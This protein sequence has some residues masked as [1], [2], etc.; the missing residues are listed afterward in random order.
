MKNDAN[1]IKE[2]KSYKLIHDHET[3]RGHNM[4]FPIIPKGTTCLKMAT[5]L[6]FIPWITKIIFATIN[7]VETRTPPLLHSTNKSVGNDHN[8]Y[9]RC[10]YQNSVMHHS[11][12]FCKS[13][14]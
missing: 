12:P 7:I 3:M 6:G 4:N 10:K 9:C 11:N 5:V 1:I 8:L 13:I 2:T 14:V